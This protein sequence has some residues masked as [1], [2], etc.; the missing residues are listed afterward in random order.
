MYCTKCGIQLKDGSKFCHKCGARYEEPADVGTDAGSS[1][2]NTS[3]ITAEEPAY[4]SSETPYDD[5]D[6]YFASVDDPVDKGKRKY[7]IVGAIAVAALVFLICFCN[8]NTFKRLFYKPADYYSYVEKRNARKNLEQLGGW[9]EAAGMD[10]SK[11]KASGRE[12]SLELNMSDDILDTMSDAFGV[13]ADFLKK[14]NITGKSAF[15][16]DLY[17]GNLNLSLGSE[18]I[19]ALN[20]ITD[21]ENDEV[22]LR[23]PE[24]SDDYLK[25]NVGDVESLMGGSKKSGKTFDKDDPLAYANMIGKLP[26][27]AKLVK[28]ANRYSDIVFDNID[29]VKRSGRTSL[30]MGGVEQKCWVLTVKLDYRDLKKLGETISSEFEDDKDAESVIR[31]LAESVDMDED[32]AWEE[33]VKAVDDLTDILADFAGTKMKVYVD[34][35]GRVIAREIEAGEDGEVTVTYGRTIHGREFGALIDVDID[36]ESYTVEGSGRKS[37]EMYSGDFTLGG[38]D[39]DS[40]GFTLNSFDHKSFNKQKINGE[41]SIKAGDIMDAFDI[42]YPGISLIEDYLAVISVKA[43]DTKAYEIG[44]KLADAKSEPLSCTY[45]FKD[46]GASKISIPD[47]AIL[48]EKASDLKGYLEDADFDRVEGNLERAGVPESI[49]RYFSYIQRLSDY[50]DYLD[51]FY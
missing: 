28:I 36:G 12:E 6:K 39:I 37:G 46:T 7:Y 49:T 47:D 1:D 40:I 44:F 9:L 3:D 42:D 45:A 10:G 21:S 17:S 4:D 5:Y 48:V 8:T 23:I 35:K 26:K 25:F 27:A 34:S 18:Q 24:L 29:D 32:D 31:E 33:A 16:G 43:K 30:E 51:M 20:A 11:D 38:T 50:I 22:Y 19:I 13:D 15:Y 14:I 41:V 2:G